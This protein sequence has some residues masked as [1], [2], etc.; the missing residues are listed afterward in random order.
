MSFLQKLPAQPF[1][2]CFQL[3]MLYIQVLKLLQ[4]AQR[5]RQHL[6]LIVSKL[7]N[8]QFS[9]LLDLFRQVRNGIAIQNQPS[10]CCFPKKLWG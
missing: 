2:H 1:W 5:I 7:K 6:Q 8:P 10:E 3:I 4:V 9:E